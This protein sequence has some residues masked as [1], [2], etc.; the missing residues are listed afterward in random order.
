MPDK[1]LE[2]SEIL[3]RFTMYLGVILLSEFL[4]SGTF[5]NLW[6]FLIQYRKISHFII[7]IIAL[8]CFFLLDDGD[9]LSVVFPFIGKHSTYSLSVVDQ[10]TVLLYQLLKSALTIGHERHTLLF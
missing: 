10:G 3:H 9:V 8:W 5:C 6:L 2:H 1:D 7:S 4:R